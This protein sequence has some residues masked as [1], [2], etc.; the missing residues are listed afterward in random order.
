MAAD[1]TPEGEVSA[2]R[3]EAAIPDFRAEAETSAAAELQ[4]TGDGGEIMIKAKNLFTSDEQKKIEEAVSKAEKT[5]SGEIAI[6]I[7]DESDSYIET[8]IFGA[9]MLSGL[10]SLFVPFFLKQYEIWFYLPAVLILYPLFYFLMNRVTVLKRLFTPDDR[11]NSAVQRRALSAFYEKG[12]YKTKDETGILIFLSLFER[13]V[14]ILGD[15][16]INA[17]IPANFW[18]DISREIAKGMFEKNHSDA[19]VSA[20]GKCGAELT[21]HFPIKP[22]D[23][24]EL[25]NKVIF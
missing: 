17:K 6:M 12:L 2:V 16:G 9:I 10:I 5:T 11:I 3:A 13:K 22:G 4:E 20:I 19:M 23:K 21:K 18:N 7:L 1:S 8:A 25:S 24:N 14:W 15:K